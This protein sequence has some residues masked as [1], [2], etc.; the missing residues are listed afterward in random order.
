M[1]VMRSAD[2]FV[3]L[4]FYLSDRASGFLY[5]EDQKHV[6]RWAVGR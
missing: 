2:E 6:V 4:W 1:T 5:L 3:V